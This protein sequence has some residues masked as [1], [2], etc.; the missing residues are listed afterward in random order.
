M[1]PDDK[2]AR[3]I[4]REA[5]RLPERM[6]LRVFQ[7]LREDLASADLGLN[8]ADQINQRMSE[9]VEALQRAA[10][11]L[12]LESQEDRLALT[13]KTFDQVPDTVRQNWSAKRVR[14]A[15]GSWERAKGVAFTDQKLPVRAARKEKRRKELG[16]RKRTTAFEL[17]SIRAWLAQSPMNKTRSAYD[18]WCRQHNQ[19]LPD[20]QR[21]A[22]TSSSIYER[23]QVPWSEIVQ[24][25]DDDRLPKR[26]R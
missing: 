25:A 19:D 11:H 12:G 9:A 6:R 26:Q 13:I 7:W 1:E 21:R 5:L 23:W 14:D 24:A 18:Q 8:E 4:T 17:D 3:E 2:L 16:Q 15:F 10:E 20:G 22:P